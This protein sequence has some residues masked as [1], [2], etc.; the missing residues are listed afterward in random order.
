MGS[1]LTHDEEA[2]AV[3]SRDGHELSETNSLI[4]SEEAHEYLLA[5]SSASRKGK[6]QTS[7]KLYTPYS[8]ITG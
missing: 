5:S 3:A 8:S 1:R 2:N 4:D 6:Q 7:S